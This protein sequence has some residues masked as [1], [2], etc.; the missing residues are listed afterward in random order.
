[1][2]TPWSLFA[3]ITLRPPALVLPMRLSLPVTETPFAWFPSPPPYGSPIRLPITVLAL[4]AIATPSPSTS[5]ITLA[6]SGSEPPTTLPCP[7]RMATPVARFH[8]P[9]VAPAAL[10]PM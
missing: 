5:A 6:S 4:A 7:A 9:L 10:V 2:S 3:E 8:I 1:M